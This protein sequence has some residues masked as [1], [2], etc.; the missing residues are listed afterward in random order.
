MAQEADV[1]TKQKQLGLGTLIAMCTGQAI[2]AG[3][4]T[5][6]GLAVGQTGRSTWIAYIVAVLVGFLIILPI[7]LYCS[8]VRFR[9]G[10]YT[11]VS[12]LLGDRW[13]GIYALGSIPMCIAG[14]TSGLAV[15]TYINSIFPSIDVKVV[16]IVVL[17]FIYFLNM[18][19][20][21]FM[22]KFQSAMTAF[23][24]I[25]LTIFCLVGMG[26][27]SP[28]TFQINAEGYFMGGSAGFLSAVVLLMYGTT[29]QSFAM[30]FSANAKNAKRDIPIM[31]IVVTGI[32][33]VLFTLIG[34][35]AGNV[36]PVEM[37]AGQPL[38]L[39]AKEIFPGPLFY[40]FIIGGPVM[41]LIT[42]LNAGYPSLCAP[43]V[44]ATQD[45]WLPKPLA[46]RNR[47]GAPYII[48][49]GMYLVSILPI[50]LNFSLTALTSNTVL[51]NSS[52]KIVAAVAIFFMPQKFG[53]H[54][55]SSRF[56]MKNIIFYPLM[57]LSVILYAA[58]ILLSAK[59]LTGSV[60]VV[61]AIVL[62][63]LVAYALYRY[64]SGK[65]KVGI[66]YSFDE[67]LTE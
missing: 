40:I 64:K 7:I 34:L 55:K 47:F 38:S 9:G 35:V 66:N 48:Y 52:V 53:E 5:A 16:A 59:G 58:V 4:I 37:V 32:I 29:G 26:K 56:Y 44:G 50:L 2:G 62:G 31:M 49:T 57:A 46:K 18:M 25:C 21:N 54:W 60:L 10:Q 28:G 51:L 11:M 67:D 63:A 39:V 6:T 42:T 24:V 3:V 19:G 30:A 27:L 22:A 61:N 13:G 14:S 17:T 8:V 15:G 43:I 33:L 1:K 45:G 36:L 20:I 65:A 23:L 41:A 12:S